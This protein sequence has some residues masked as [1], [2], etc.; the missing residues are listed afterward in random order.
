MAFIT[1]NKF[2]NAFKDYPGFNEVKNVYIYFNDFMRDVFDSNKYNIKPLAIYFDN[3]YISFNELWE[4][5]PDF[6]FLAKLTD[7]FFKTT[8]PTK[9]LRKMTIKNQLIETEKYSYYSK[10]FIETNE[11]WRIKQFEKLLA[12]TIHK[13]LDDIAKECNN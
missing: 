9:I 12:N 5:L 13:N 2:M 11:D 1:L 8:K 7:K 3:K 10:S 4:R 6:K